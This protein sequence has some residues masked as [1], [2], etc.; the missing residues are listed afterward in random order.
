MNAN[1]EFNLDEN[2]I[3]ISKEVIK[4][5]QIPAFPIESGFPSRGFLKDFLDFASPLTEASTQFHI[6]TALATLSAA[7]GR[8]VYLD[9]GIKP[10]YPN[11]YVL[12]VGKSGI[13]RK[14]SAIYPAKLLIDRFN[15]NILM[16]D[17]FS[18]ESLYDALRK[19]P[20]LTEQICKLFEP[21]N[22]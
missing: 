19:N 21:L 9:F 12:V 6:G 5:R 1:D 22:R 14:S 15:K 3:E 20:F 17:V 8:R 18:T 7:T 10:I 11:L 13:S 2:P 4:E 16:W